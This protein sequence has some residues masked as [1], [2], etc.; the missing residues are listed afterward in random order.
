MAQLELLGV[1]GVADIQQSLSFFNTPIWTAITHLGDGLLPLLLFVGACIA[2]R[3]R[4]ALV[5]GILSSSTGIIVGLLKQLLQDPRPYLISD[6]F[7]IH[8]MGSG[9]GMPSGHSATGLITLAVI[10]MFL[11]K[12]YFLVLIPLIVL[13]GLSRVYLGVHTLGQVMAG[14]LVALVIIG[15]YWIFARD[16]ASFLKFYSRAVT[17]ILVTCSTLV[18]VLA[19]VYIDLSV[20][21][22]FSIPD[23]WQQNDIRAYE[24][25]AVPEDEYSPLSLFQSHRIVL[26]GLYA[27][28]C[29]AAL[30]GW[31]K[32]DKMIKDKSTMV[33]N[34]IIVVAAFVAVFVLSKILEHHLYVLFIV[35]TIFPIF[36]VAWSPALSHRLVSRQTML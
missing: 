22:Q 33:V 14:W 15:T 27:G 25:L 2:R 26:V 8:A 11:D 9:F 12:R 5:I 4:F 21:P 16:T 18:F 17:L 36:T 28:F 34:G 3:I 31:S 32:T 7:T 35:F 1:T 10:G 30:L 29:M 13:V 19:H 23:L 24:L 6:Q 20:Q